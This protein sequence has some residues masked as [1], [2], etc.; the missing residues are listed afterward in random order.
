[1]RPA[2]RALDAVQSE[3]CAH[4]AKVLGANEHSSSGRKM[5]LKQRGNIEGC[6]IEAHSSVLQRLSRHIFICVTHVPV[7][8]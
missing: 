8:T 3:V 7:V 4:T 1:M 5:T 2:P 6:D